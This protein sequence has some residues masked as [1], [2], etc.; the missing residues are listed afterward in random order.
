MEIAADTD[1]ESL[2]VRVAGNSLELPWLKPFRSDQGGTLT[3]AR[4]SKWWKVG[5]A[6]N[7]ERGVGS[8]EGDSDAS[9]LSRLN[10]QSSLGTAVMIAKLTNGDPWIVTRRYGR[11]TTAVLTSSLD[12]DWN[13]FPAKQDFVPWLH[14]FLFALASPSTSRNVDVG[15]PL[16]LN[17][18]PT[19]KVTDYEFL[20]PGNKSFAAER[21]DD[22]FQ[23]G[24]RLHEVTLPGVYRFTARSLGG[25]PSAEDQHFVANFD[26]VESDLTLLTEV[27]REALIHKDRLTFATD[28][29]GMQRLMFADGSRSE[30]WW[31]LL[32]G[33][34]AF[35]AFEVWMT[36]RM[37]HGATNKV[38]ASS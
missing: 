33:F 18:A 38:A 6:R 24:A 4:F 11:G 21:I 28:L 12:A 32:Y 16:S 14:E 23:P 26:R 15:T 10:P 9:Q 7:S 30:F 36:R 22:D 2:G 1:K 5:P 31:L 13:T 25:K 20:G 3:D 35:T 17:I 19:L 34:L 29:A 27:Q 37:L 8:K